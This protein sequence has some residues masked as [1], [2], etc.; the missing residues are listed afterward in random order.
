MAMAILTSV[1]QFVLLCR[2]GIDLL[3][4][5]DCA[6]MVYEDP[7]THTTTHTH[8]EELLL[9]AKEEE[10]LL[11]AKEGPLLLAKEEPFALG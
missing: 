1:A 7:A 10:P 4:H 6:E 2:F 9:L 8:R 11:L 5:Y 3:S